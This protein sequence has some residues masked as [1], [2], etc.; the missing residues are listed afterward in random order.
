[1]LTTV[2]GLL[3]GL[4]QGVRHAL[5][6][7][8]LAAVSTLVA[9]RKTA[10]SAAS[11]AV[12]WGVGHA[13]VLLAFGGALLLLR[14]QVPERVGAAFEL[15]VAAMLVVLGVRALRRALVR[16]VSGEAR[17][18]GHSVGAHAHAGPADHLHVRGFTLAR[19]PLVVGSIHGLAGSGALAAIVLSRMPSP[20][21]GLV[22]M[23]VYGGGAMLGMAMLAGVA[24]V[25]LARLART[26]RGI[27]VLLGTTGALSL[28]LGVAW[29][30]AAAG[31]A[32]AS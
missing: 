17:P 23:A 9:E 30:W 2:L 22:Y 6:P 12:A 11:Y 16:D 10:R 4:A 18:H 19:Q 7:D 25:P 21:A 1:M 8:H 29:G 15:V 27:P 5:E 28:L 3:W 32:L 26:R 14:G 20:L 24:G 31:V 13:L